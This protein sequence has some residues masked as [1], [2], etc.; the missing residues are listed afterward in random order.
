[1]QILGA[2]SHNLWAT[3]LWL[4]GVQKRPKCVPIYFILFIHFIKNLK[5]K[6]VAILFLLVSS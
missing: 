3:T 1:M 2:R 5:L 6:F 4:R